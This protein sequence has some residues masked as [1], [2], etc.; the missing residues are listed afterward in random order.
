LVENYVDIGYPAASFIV[1]S[2]LLIWIVTPNPVESIA[3]QVASG[4][5]LALTL[6]GINGYIQLS[7]E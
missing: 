3:I 7:A 5:I 1:G 6:N 2:A 4:V